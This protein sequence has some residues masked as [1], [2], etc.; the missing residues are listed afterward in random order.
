MRLRDRR[1]GATTTRTCSGT[2]RKTKSEVMACRCRQR[3]AQR[4]NARARVQREADEDLLDKLDDASKI[5]RSGAFDAALSKGVGH[6][7]P[8]G[9][10]RGNKS[11]AA[12]GN[13]RLSRTSSRSKKKSSSGWKRRRRV[14]PRPRI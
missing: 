10:E 7:K 2:S 13:D 12:K 9:W 1:R 6:L 4:G 11:R 5:C 3:I 14:T 8:D